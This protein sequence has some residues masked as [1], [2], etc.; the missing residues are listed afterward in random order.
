M[1]VCKPR[2]DERPASNWKWTPAEPELRLVEGSYEVYALAN[3]IENGGFGELTGELRSEPQ[4]LVLA[5]GSPIPRLELELAGRTGVR[6]R[7]TFAKDGIT[8]GRAGILLLGLAR[9]EPLDPER[10]ATSRKV[11]WLRGDDEYAFLDLDPGRY[12]LGVVRTDG[13]PTCAAREIEIAGGIVRCDF[14]V[15]PLDLSQFLTV[16]LRGTAGDAIEGRS[17]QFM[18]RQDGS[19]RGS[20]VL[21]MRGEDGCYVLAIPSESLA[22]YFGGTEGHAFELSVETKAYGSRTFVL[23]PGQTELDASFAPPATLDAVV[24]GIASPE[25]ARRLRLTLTRMPVG[26]SRL[27]SR[28]DEV[29][30]RADGTAHFDEHEAGNYELGLEILPP[31]EADWSRRVTLLFQPVELAAGSNAARV[32]IPVLYSLAVRWTGSQR[33]ERLSLFP[34]GV[35]LNDWILRRETRWANPDENGFAR[36]EDVPAGTYVLSGRTGASG[37]IEKR[38]E[39]PCGEVSIGP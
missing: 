18:H 26:E 21:P 37:A 8:G 14:E 27:S 22:A 34:T 38:I 15:P 28:S 31:G 6:G 33:A 17:F 13:A 29:E 20:G 3:L 1:L 4:Q 30:V 39:V 7:V 11:L 12:A 32:T 2:A 10:L 36:F 35:E 24:A 9:D 23:A 19:S 16:R 25:D 5:P